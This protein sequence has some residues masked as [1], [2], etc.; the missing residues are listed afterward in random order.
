[1]VAQP[2]FL[3]GPAEWR[4]GLKRK[5]IIRTTEVTIETEE[6]VLLRAIANRQS[7]PMWCPGCHRHV[8][9]VTTEHAAELVGVTP[10]TIYRWIDDASVHFVENGRHVLICLPALSLHAAADTSVPARPAR[11][12]KP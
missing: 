10:R 9:M 3:Q 6:N 11:G 4:D 12:T 7:S 8:Q 5:R 2:R 1:M